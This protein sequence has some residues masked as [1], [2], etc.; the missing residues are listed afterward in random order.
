MVLVDGSGVPLGTT[1]HAASEAEVKVVHQTLATVRVPRAGPG[2]PRSRPH[3]LIGDKAYD[4]D[5]FRL[6]LRASGIEV[7]APHRR[8]RRR[9]SLQDGR[10]LRRFQRRWKVERTFAWLQAF[11]RLVVRWDRSAKMFLAFLHVACLVITL[12]HL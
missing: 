7:I 1:V 12:R 11:R 4:C 8:N 3:R 6:T 10:A 9:S 5:A 2:R